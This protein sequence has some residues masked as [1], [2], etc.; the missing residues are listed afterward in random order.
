MG[1][2]TRGKECED[3]LNVFPTDSNAYV[4]NWNYAQILDL[5]MNRFEEAYEQYIHVSN[6]Y[7]ETDYQKDGSQ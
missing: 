4:V 7:L 1:I 3:Y 6:D 2:Q 5:K